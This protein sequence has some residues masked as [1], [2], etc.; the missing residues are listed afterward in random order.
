MAK[1]F[2]NHPNYLSAFLLG[3]ALSLGFFAFNGGLNAR[4]PNASSRLDQVLQTGLSA[5]PARLNST[6]LGTTP[7]DAIGTDLPAASQV[8]SVT[9]QIVVTN[10]EGAGNICVGSTTWALTCAALSVNCTLGNAAMGSVVP[11]GQARTFRYD[12]TRRPCIV[13]SAANMDVQSERVTR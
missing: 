1:F 4:P 9:Q 10:L 6:A 3:V 13:G 2:R 7:T 12:G 5:D 8:D 11:A